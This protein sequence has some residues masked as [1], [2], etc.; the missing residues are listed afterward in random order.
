MTQHS[1]GGR[2]LEH[3]TRCFLGDCGHCLLE[4]IVQAFSWASWQASE[5]GND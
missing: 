2:Q 5:R 1:L 4:A 3:V